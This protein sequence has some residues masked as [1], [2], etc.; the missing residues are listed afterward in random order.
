M[1]EGR[2][3]LKGLEEVRGEDAV[4]RSVSCEYHFNQSIGKYAGKLSNPTDLYSFSR[5]A[6]K[7]KTSDISTDYDAALDNIE[8]FIEKDRKKRKNNNISTRP[9]G[10]AGRKG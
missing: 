2:G 9:C 10:P 4:K 8:E 7:L 6:K 1:D 3:V 5:M